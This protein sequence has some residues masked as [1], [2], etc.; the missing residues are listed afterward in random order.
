[1]A[2][3]S[4]QIAAR[5]DKSLSNSMFIDGGDVRSFCAFSGKNLIVPL[6]ESDEILIT[7]NW[8]VTQKVHVSSKLTLGHHLLLPG[9]DIEEFP[10][11]VTY[12]DGSYDLINVRTGKKDVLI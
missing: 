12:A 7:K 5:Y 8:K 4:K 2:T 10:F 1:M 3:S 11:L 6:K 9:F